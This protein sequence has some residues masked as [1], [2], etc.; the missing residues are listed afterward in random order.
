[1]QH[2]LKAAAIAA[3]AEVVAAQFFNKIFFAVDGAVA[4]LDVGFRGVSFAALTAALES[5]GIR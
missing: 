3:G 5:R 1:M 4:A 2:F